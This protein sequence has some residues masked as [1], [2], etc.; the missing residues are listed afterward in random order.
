MEPEIKKLFEEA[1]SVYGNRFQMATDA[2]KDK[3]IE[4]YGDSPEI[5]EKC[6][7]MKAAVAEALISYCDQKIQAA[8]DAKRRKYK[9]T[10][11][12]CHN[13]FDKPKGGNFEL[14]CA[15]TLLCL[16]CI[17]GAVFTYGLS[18][19]FVVIIWAISRVTCTKKRCPYCGSNTF[20]RND[21]IQT[22]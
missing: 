3:I 7:T 4:Y 11:T 5:F 21:T 16:I 6:K 19:I 18:L 10:C 17:L 2:Q 20:V 9:Y 12:A 15:L 14:D 13:G 1:E 8:E 22:S